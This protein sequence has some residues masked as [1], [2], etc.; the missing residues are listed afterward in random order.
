MNQL[1]F[2]NT[3]ISKEVKRKAEK[4]MSR[5]KILDAIIE[6]KKMDLEPRLTQNP[7][8]SEIQR[9][10]QFYSSVEN[11]A[12]TEFEIEEYLRTKRKLHLVFESLKPLQQHIWED[13]YILG[14]RDVEVYN[15]LELTDKTYYRAKREM[16]AIVAEAFGLINN[17]G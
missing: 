10:N 9:G 12:I 4:L 5:Y 17:V 14:K 6:S 11:S 15:D 13:R 7:E 3:T 16:V 2:L 8:P 1:S